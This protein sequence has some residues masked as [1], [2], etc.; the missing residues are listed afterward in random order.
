MHS[1]L[2]GP[3]RRE[4]REKVGS[5]RTVS[6]IA[7]WAIPRRNRRASFLRGKEAREG[8]RVHFTLGGGES[9]I[10][11]GSQRARAVPR[12]RAPAPC[13][14]WGETLTSSTTTKCSCSHADVGIQV[15][16]SSGNDDRAHRER[17][18]SG[19][20]GGEKVKCARADSGTLSQDARLRDECSDGATR[21][22]RMVRVTPRRV[23]GKH[24]KPK[25]Y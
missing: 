5:R 11:R 15:H 16:L 19:G 22:T 25:G 6:Q 23:R 8:N 12:R 21:G 1:F 2:I 3:N 10:Y 9:A 13:S 18:S 20:G 4:D 24:A 17:G 7:N 14:S